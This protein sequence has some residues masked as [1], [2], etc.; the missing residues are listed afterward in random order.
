MWW[1]PD[2]FGIEHTY[3]YHYLCIHGFILL[4][5]QSAQ[6]WL[7][8]LFTAEA[9]ITAM[10][11]HVA[12][13]KNW[14]LEELC[15]NVSDVCC[16]Q[17][18][19]LLKRVVLWEN[20][21]HTS[22][23]ATLLL[24]VVHLVLQVATYCMLVCRLQPVVYLLISINLSSLLNHKMCGYEVWSSHTSNNIYIMHV[25]RFVHKESTWMLVNAYQLFWINPGWTVH[26]EGYIQS[27]NAWCYKHYYSAGSIC[28]SY[29]VGWHLV[30]SGT[31]G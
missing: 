31:D 12:R 23:C 1:I 28:L 2:V 27:W 4:Y 13:A 14:S 6:I 30:T 16:K 24:P 21:L 8:G 15:L 19:W 3:E 10:R 20:T 22:S 9:Y 7:G 18:T 26:D 25:S 11:Q 17:H 5:V 29:S